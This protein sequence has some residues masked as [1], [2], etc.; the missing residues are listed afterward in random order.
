[1]RSA[2]FFLENFV[3][4]TQIVCNIVCAIIFAI[5]SSMHI[6]FVATSSTFFVTSKGLTVKI[7]NFFLEKPEIYRKIMGKTE[8]T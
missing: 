4:A 1:M 6:S 7:M 2:F 3:I 5:F 8:K